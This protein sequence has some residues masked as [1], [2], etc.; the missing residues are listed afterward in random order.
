V[1]RCIDVEFP[2]GKKVYAKI[3]EKI[4]HTDQ[5]QKNGGSGEHPEPFQYFLA[6]IATCSGIY[7]L[8]FCLQRELNTAGLSLKMEYGWDPDK[9]MISRID[10]HLDLPENFPHKYEKA[11]IKAIEL[12]A[13]KRHLDPSIK[14]VIQIVR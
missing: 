14:A 10:M 3:G 11:I 6:S 1:S 9:K 12:C 8:E 13:V 7:A 4:V 2:G 5:S